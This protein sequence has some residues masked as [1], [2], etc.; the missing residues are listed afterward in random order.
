MIARHIA[1]PPI[2][3]KDVQPEGVLVAD[4]IAERVAVEVPS[5]GLAD[6][7][8]RQI[9]PRIRR[10]VPIPV[11]KKPALRLLATTSSIFLV[12]LRT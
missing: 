8:Y 12:Q 2:A 1:R 5:A 11:V 4:R 3:D 6:R 9:A 10:E 7:I